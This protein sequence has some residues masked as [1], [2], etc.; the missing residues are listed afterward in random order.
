MAA[1]LMVKAYGGV[2]EETSADGVCVDASR[3]V[4]TSCASACGCTTRDP[5]AWVG[6]W[7][8]LSLC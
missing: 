6:W 7:R 4:V 2:H 8:R 1:R 5:K 3:K